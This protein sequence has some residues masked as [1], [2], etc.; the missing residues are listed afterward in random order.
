M[1]SHIVCCRNSY[2]IVMEN[3]NTSVKSVR[4][5]KILENSS[6]VVFQATSILKQKSLATQN[7][8]GI[9]FIIKTLVLKMD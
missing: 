9:L 6:D 5:R 1:V 7:L 3:F 8:V 4:I 2:S